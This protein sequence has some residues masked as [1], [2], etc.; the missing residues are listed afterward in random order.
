[1]A[2]SSGYRLIRQDDAGNPKRYQEL[3]T[4]E[5]V[6]LPKHLEPGRWEGGDEP[7]DASRYTSRAYHDLEV[8]KLWLKTWQFACRA[9]QLLQP[10]DCFI[11]EIAHRSVILVRGH[12]GQVRAFYN[13]CLHR[14]RA[15]RST[16]GN[17]S[18]LR[19][20]FHGFTWSLEGEF[21]SL[22]CAWD[23][24]HLQPQN[25][26]LPQLRCETWNGF[27]FVSFDPNAPALIDFLGVLPQHFAPYGLERSCTLVH[28][29]KRIACNWKVGQEAFF[30][31]LHSRTTHPHL[32]TFIAD[33]DSQYDVFGDN[34]SRM[35]TPSGEPSSNVEGVTPDQVLLDNLASSGRMA[36]LDSS[37]IKLPDGVGVREYIADINRRRFGEASG[38][39]LSTA[40]DSELQDAILYSVF[41]NMQVWAGYYVNIAYRFI[42]DGDDPDRCIFDFRMLGRYR[43][44]QPCPAAPQ[45]Q[46]LGEADTFTDKAAGIGPLSKVFDQ[47]MRNLPLITLGLKSSRDGAVQLAHYQ[48]LRIRHFH[49][50]LEHY[51]G[52]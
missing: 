39:D 5:K 8:K 41:P 13:S 40:S 48:E 45:T 24:K 49:R 32:V 28:I 4:R 46:H 38:R 26:R 50:R 25:L 2:D 33:V 15:L 10:G 1:M 35:I 18:E 19:C 44:G 6:P 14:G 47:D 42:P 29:Q 31:S 37:K 22:P 11:Y 51:L 20:P 3:L 30:E 12:D 17:T 36:G 27:V 34:I 23:F 16:A 9:E 43:E 7:I 52:L 21:V